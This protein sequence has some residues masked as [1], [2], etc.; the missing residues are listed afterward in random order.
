MGALFLVLGWPSLCPSKARRS[1][2][3]PVKTRGSK[4]AVHEVNPKADTFISRSPCGNP[5]LGILRG[6]QSLG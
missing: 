3:F 5:V 4:K 6:P 1:P 2:S